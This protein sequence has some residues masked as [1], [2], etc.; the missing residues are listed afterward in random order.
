M[1]VPPS[2]IDM[3]IAHR[4]LSDARS[5]CF[6]PSYPRG[7]DTE[8]DPP[9]NPRLKRYFSRASILN[10]TSRACFM[11]VPINLRGG[12][13]QHTLYG[14]RGL[15]QIDVN[16]ICN[17]LSVLQY[18]LSLLSPQITTPLPSLSCYSRETQSHTNLALC[19]LNKTYQCF[20]SLY[21]LYFQ[22]LSYSNGSKTP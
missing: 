8:F 21:N 4:P 16:N 20:I 15:R 1:Y 9:L 5:S 2:D 10:G 14:G 7:L 19:I 12:L 11:S 22:I 3:P 6:C 17:Y 18:A 13:Q